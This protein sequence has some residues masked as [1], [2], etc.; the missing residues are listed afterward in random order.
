[1]PFNR[2]YLLL[3]HC[4]YI[5]ILH[6]SQNLKTPQDRD[7]AHLSDNLST[8]ANTSYGKA[9]DKINSI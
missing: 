7:H 5:S 3:F 6:R 9:E 8:D 1:M 2:S 4:N